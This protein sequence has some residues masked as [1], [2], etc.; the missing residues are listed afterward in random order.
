MKGAEVWLKGERVLVIQ[1]VITVDHH[2]SIA[3]VA[4]PR[5]SQEILLTPSTL[6]LPALL[7]GAAGVGVEV[8]HGVVVAGAAQPCERMTGLGVPVSVTVTR[9]TGVAQTGGGPEGPWQTLITPRTCCP[10]LTVETDMS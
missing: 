1:T 5:V 8:G 10:V 2:G 6:V 3:V 4:V 7:R 9:S